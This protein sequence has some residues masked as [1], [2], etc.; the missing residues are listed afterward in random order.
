MYCSMVACSLCMHVE[1]HSFLSYF[2]FNGEKW[3]IDIEHMLTE[4]WDKECF[5]NNLSWTECNIIFPF[6][7]QIKQYHQH[8]QRFV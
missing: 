4:V 8:T 1:L 7:H 5:Y 6:L 2:G 3:F